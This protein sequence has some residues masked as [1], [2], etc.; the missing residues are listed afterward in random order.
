MI[1]VE[2][3]VTSECPIYVNRSGL[4]SDDREDHVVYRE[5]CIVYILLILV[6]LGTESSWKSLLDKGD[7]SE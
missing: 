1:V 5:D 2:S 6:W 7:E 4:R 3:V